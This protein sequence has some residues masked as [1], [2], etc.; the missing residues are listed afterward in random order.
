MNET[1]T[2][3]SSLPFTTGTYIDKK[4]PFTGNVSIRGRILT[5]VVKTHKMNR[6]LIMKMDYL[7]YIKKYQR[8][9]KRHTNL[10]APPIRANV[11]GHS[12]RLL[13]SGGDRRIARTS[14]RTVTGVAPRMASS[15]PS[16]PARPP[17]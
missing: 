1:L 17:P 4:C 8:Y 2:F 3:R 5:G 12:N 11:S 13:T 14:P 16:P 10:P 6:T 7:H 9:E 15:P